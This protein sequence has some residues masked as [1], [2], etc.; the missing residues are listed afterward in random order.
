MSRLHPYTLLTAAAALPAVAWLVPA[1]WGGAGALT[2]AVLLV[3]ASTTGPHRRLAAALAAVAPFWLFLILL[4]PPA[5]A[6]AIGLRVATLVVA[7]VWVQAALPARRLLEALVARGWPAGVA[8][9]CGATLAAVP[10]LRARGRA[11]VEAQRCRG[12]SPR[13]G[14]VARLRAL[15]VLAL[16]LVLSALHDVD[17]RALALETRALGRA[18]RTPLD[19][20][21]DRAVERATRW[22]ILVALAALALWRLA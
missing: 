22:T 5:R 7:A 11:I 3:I 2:A 17:E 21:A 6:S 18:R 12:L 15:R 8:Y 1:P 10:E 19:P 20:P 13:G 4:H 16:P 14:P 9:V